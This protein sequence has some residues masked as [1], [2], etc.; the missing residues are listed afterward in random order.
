[1][2][3][4]RS[5]RMRAHFWASASSRHA[6]RRF[7]KK[8]EMDAVRLARK[9]REPDLFHGEAQRSARAN[10]RE[11]R[12]DLVEHAARRAAADARLRIAVKRVLADVVI[13]GREIGRAE[14]G[15]RVEDAVEV[16]SPVTLAHG[17]VELAQAMEH[18]AVE[19]G[20]RARSEALALGKVREIGEREAQRVAQ[21]AIELD[22]GLEDL[23]ADAQVLG[24]I[25]ARDP[26]AQDFGAAFGRDLLRRDR[27]ARRFRH[28]LA[29]LVD[30]EAVG[31]HGVVRRPPARAAALEQRG[32]EPAAMLVRAF[33]IERGGPGEI[34][35]RTR[36]EHERVR[37]ARNRTRRRECRRPARSPSFCI[38]R[39]GTVPACL[40]TTHR[41][42]PSRRPQRCAH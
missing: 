36:L 40:R 21:L 20:H 31:E 29:V 8:P 3:T 18:E 17:L 42:L 27:R 24:E 16:V 30:D 41:R 6:R 7:G 14:I 2:T 28:L 9:A 4:W 37:R 11:P 39:R 15:E 25:R 5:S 13:E 10:G 35:L 32:L 1:M 33:E 22:G 34:G 12:E 38:R 23:G 19:L 26:Q